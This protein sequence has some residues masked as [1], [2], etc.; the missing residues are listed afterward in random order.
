MTEIPD[1]S[2]CVGL[3]RFGIDNN[4]LKSAHF[5][6]GFGK[7]RNLSTIVLSNNQIASIKFDDLKSLN[8][9]N[10][11]A[12]DLARCGLSL[13]DGSIFA[14]FPHLQSVNLGYNSFN[15]TSLRNI[16][17]HLQTS[18]ISSLGLGGIKTDRLPGDFFANFSAVP[19]ITLDMS[20]SQIDLLDNGTFTS[21]KR[22]QHLYLSRSKIVVIA[23]GAF[24]DIG[25]N[26]TLK[27][28]NNNLETVP[29]GLPPSLQQLDLSHNVIDKLSAHQ[30]INLRNLLKLNLANCKIHQIVNDAFDGVNNL[31][32]LNLDYNTFGG[33]NIGNKV[34]QPLIHLKTLS[35][36]GN[37]MKTIPT[38][39]K[40]FESLTE[41]EALDMSDNDCTDIAPGIFGSL[42]SLKTLDLSGNDLGLYVDQ[43][44]SEIFA[45]L[46]KLENLNVKNSHLY[47]LPMELFSD[48]TSLNKLILTNNQIAEWERGLFRGMGLLKIVNLSSNGIAVINKTSVED[49]PDGVVL[50]LTEN[51]FSCWC[52]LTWF[53]NW[54]DSQAN[55]S[56]VSLPG[57]ASYQCHSPTS[58]VGKSVL[59]FRP[60]SIHRNCFP[61]PWMEIIISAVTGT[62]A[63]FTAFIMVIYKY[64]WSLKLRWYKMR[65]PFPSGRR[66]ES[67]YA[68]LDSDDEE[69]HYDVCVLYGPNKDD[70]KWVKSVGFSID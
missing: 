68:R 6:D 66:R 46:T 57:N 69:P 5:P 34:L 60:E 48:L 42:K 32:V 64:R 29:P 22:L 8:N 36:K 62:V 52:D 26:L 53:R 1:L 43:H 55:S 38:Q 51:P 15:L 56:R 49:L 19:L 2:Y 4:R 41:L 58:M 17:R 20:L 27:L 21:L 47:R 9:S 24:G 7:L 23:D 63:L 40:L 10:I 16:M 14:M 70:C 12:I 59:D 3:T 54:I 39:S 50:D 33:S 28:D 11:R 61:L 44:A 67:N 37:R 25:V 18:Q 30:F 45:H 65:R 13:L 35:L 31:N